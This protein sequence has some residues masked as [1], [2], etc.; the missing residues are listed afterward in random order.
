MSL[1]TILAAAS[2]GT[3][4]DGALEIGCR[5][6]RRFEAHLEGLHIRIDPRQV[7]ARTAGEGFAMPKPRQTIDQFAIDIATIA[8]N[9]KAAFEAAI[10][11]HDIPVAPPRI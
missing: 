6:A 8:T 4:S 11:R 5:L 1:R 10:V 2:G 3:A 9:T 7:F